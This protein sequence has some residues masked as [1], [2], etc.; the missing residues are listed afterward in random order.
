M[1]DAVS[2]GKEE[3]EIK[4]PGS[5]PGIAGPSSEAGKFMKSN[6]ILVLSSWRLVDW[7][8]Y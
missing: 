5:S 7:T 4:P 2:A 6:L 3:K 8:P 1:N